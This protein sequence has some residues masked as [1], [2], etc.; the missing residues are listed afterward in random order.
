DDAMDEYLQ[1]SPDPARLKLLTR[2]SWILSIVVYVIV[3]AMGRF[4]IPIE[5]DLSFL[6]ALHAILNTLV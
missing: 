5:A 2:I 1:L 4:T 6:P 3:V